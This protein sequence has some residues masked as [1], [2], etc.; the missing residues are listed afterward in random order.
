[1]TLQKIPYFTE[2]NN[3]T[4]QFVVHFYKA[5]TQP[6]NLFIVNH[7]SFTFPNRNIFLLHVRYVII[8]L[9]VFSDVKT[10][11]LLFPLSFKRVWFT[12]KKKRKINEEIKA[13]NKKAKKRR[14][15]KTILYYYLVKDL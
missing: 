8:R 13:C 11:F 12:E 5:F 1:M 4:L 6:V 14:L 3:E 15:L 9:F 7:V 10:V 2:R